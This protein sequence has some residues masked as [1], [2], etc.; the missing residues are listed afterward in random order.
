MSLLRKPK[1]TLVQG[2]AGPFLPKS[3]FDRWVCLP[4]VR[5]C[6]ACREESWSPELDRSISVTGLTSGVSRQGHYSELPPRER[7]HMAALFTNT[8]PAFRQ[9]GYVTTLM[10]SIS[11]A[12]Y[13]PALD[14][15]ASPSWHGR[16]DER[17]CVWS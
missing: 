3:F 12:I 17:C 16:S 7:A 14:M 11:E 15:G 9:A 8:I 2:D 10:S 4:C 6:G 5:V 1:A 13:P